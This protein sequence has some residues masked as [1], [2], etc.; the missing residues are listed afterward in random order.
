MAQ[1][2]GIALI[3][4]NGTTIDFISTKY[5]SWQRMG[6]AN[7]RTSINVGVSELGTEE[8][9]IPNT[10]TGPITATKGAINK[11]QDQY[12]FEF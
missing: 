12:L 9:E 10:W 4:L 2:D 8:T 11:K 3:D 5:P 6:P 7:E 1:P